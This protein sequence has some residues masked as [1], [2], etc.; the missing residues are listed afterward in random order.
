MSMSMLQCVLNGM[1][2]YVYMSLFKYEYVYVHVC[3]NGWIPACMYAGRCI[4]KYMYISIA[5]YTYIYIY[6]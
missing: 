1:C 2:L 3:M 5:T 4:C 6:T